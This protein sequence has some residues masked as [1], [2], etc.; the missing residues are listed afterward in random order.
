MAKVLNIIFCADF[1]VTIDMY[2]AFLKYDGRTAKYKTNV[3]PIVI[4]FSAVQCAFQLSKQSVF[5]FRTNTE[6]RGF[7][8]ML[9]KEEVC[10]LSSHGTGTE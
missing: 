6:L 9:Q 2:F 10:K 7:S 5:C 4:D 8:A 3:I 1:F